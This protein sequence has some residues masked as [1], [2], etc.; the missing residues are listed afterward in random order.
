VQPKIPKDDVRALRRAIW[1]CQQVFEAFPSVGS[2][3][4]PTVA[5]P[6]TVLHERNVREQR[7][8]EWCVADRDRVSKD[9][10]VLFGG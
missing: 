8:H 4:G 7:R 3:F 9:D 1:G 6:R 10:D 2:L 5:T